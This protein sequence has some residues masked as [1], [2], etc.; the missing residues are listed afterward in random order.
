MTVFCFL[1]VRSLRSLRSV[2]AV[3]AVTA[4]CCAALCCAVLGRDGM[5]LAVFP[6]AIAIQPGPPVAR[7]LFIHRSPDAQSA[8]RVVISCFTTGQ[9]N[10]M[11]RYNTNR[12]RSIPSGHFS[13]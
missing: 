2:T 8:L 13:F 12:K 4:V 5:G 3:A 1:T 6:N 10:K 11:P 9:E 7:L